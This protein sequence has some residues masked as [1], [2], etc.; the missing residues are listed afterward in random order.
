MSL[1][2]DTIREVINHPHYNGSIVKADLL[3]EL[4][5][6]YKALV[7]H[8]GPRFKLGPHFING[9]LEDIMDAMFDVE[10]KPC[11]GGYS[12]RWSVRDKS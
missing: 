1:L 8:D 2:T 10:I 7:R 3:N 5:C 4:R 9:E 12:R 6:N 11:G